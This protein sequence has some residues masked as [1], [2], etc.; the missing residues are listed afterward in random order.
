M[1]SVWWVD[2]LAIIVAVLTLAALCES[3]RNLTRPGRV[4]FDAYDLDQAAANEA[5]S[6]HRDA[7]AWEAAR[8][9]GRAGASDG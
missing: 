6:E 9:A 2:V 4:F 3:L 1:S 5:W 8:L 7:E